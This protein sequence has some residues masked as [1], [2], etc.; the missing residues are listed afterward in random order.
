MGSR[1]AWMVSALNIC[2]K[3]R[4]C[5]PALSAISRRRSLFAACLV[6]LLLVSTWTALA[7]TYIYDPNGRLAVATNDAGES[8]RYR[9]DELGNLVAIERLAAD[10]LA[11]FG[12]SPG[13]GASGVAVRISGQGFSSTSGQNSVR[14]NGAVASVSI[15]SSIDL[16]A[17]VPAGATTGPITVTVGS[18]TASSTTDFIVDENARPPVIT[19]VSPQIASIGTA[20]TVDG[21]TL[22][23]VV[24]QTTLRLNQRPTLPTTLTN[25]QA[26]FPVP[27]GTSSGR[28]SVRTPYGNALS[29]QDVLVTPDSI[30]P[31]EIAQLKRLALDAAAQG[32]SVTTTGHYGAALFDGSSGDYLSAQFSS[33]S[34][35]NIN[36]ALYSISNTVLASGTVSSNSP[37]FHLP[38][39]PA[40]GTYLLLMKPMTGPVTWNLA[41]EKATSIDVNGDSSPVAT[42]AP[43]QSKRLLFTA[44]TGANL[45]L[46]ISDLVTPGSTSRVSINVDKPDGSSSTLEYCYASNNGCQLN[47]SNLAAGIYSVII[48]PPSNG[49]RTMSLQTMLSSNVIGPLARDMAQTLILARRG[50]NG[51]LTFAGTAGETMTLQL[52][53]QTTVP[54]NRT[55]YYTVYKPDGSLLTS[56][57]TTSAATLNLPNLPVTGNYTMFVDPR[58]GETLSVQMLLASGMTGE[59][60][61]DGESGSYTTT[62]LGQNVYLTFT[63]DAGQNLGL[64]ISNIV[65]PGSSSAIQVDVYGP[66]GGRLHELYCSEVYSRCDAN[67]PNLTAGIYSIVVEPPVD[68]NRTMSFQVTLSSD[69]TGELPRDTAAALNLARRGQNGRFTFTGTQGETVALQVVDQAT[70]PAEQNVYYM[71]YRPDGSY[72]TSMVTAAPETLNIS[73]LPVTG[74][75][76]V[77]V[78]PGFGAALVAETLLASGAR[79]LIELN[80]ASETVAT[81]IPG[82]HAYLAFTAAAGADLGLGISDLVTSWPYSSVFVDVRKPDGTNLTSRNCDAQYF[83]GCGLDLSDLEA[84][85]YTVVVVPPHDGQR[86][87]SFKAT[88]SSDVVQTMQPDVVTNLSLARRGQNGQLAFAGVE[89]QTVALQVTGQATVPVNRWS[90]Y[91]VYAPDGSY[92]TGTMTDSATTLDLPNLP[93]TGNYTVFVDPEQGEALNV[94]LTLDTTP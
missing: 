14:F 56:M 15:A 21:Q 4:A 80:G 26:V 20:I 65:T 61:I 30:L 59:I 38:R 94:Q 83:H 49:G 76:T 16:T 13:R 68:G 84:G 51:M 12:F 42:V 22:A 75:Y 19:N 10:D 2:A 55:T 27:S 78:D 6:T 66:D 54:A 36:Y 7:T 89:G 69:V 90:Y 87:M 39:L 73:N 72:L 48:Q 41:I 24:N 53:G 85:T 60:E 77:F 71:V 91:S 11:V 74:T 81:T 5:V 70:E 86:T 92:L 46:G 33:I 35:T 82:Q 64:G 9:Y 67:L 40:T 32:F 88:L 45:G 31:G 47:L 50:Q 43:A 1:T 93:A 62:M 37:T 57:G 28:V 29:E 8:A 34:A 44:S 63:A 25:S 3:K 79:D 17:I 52:T 58:Y 18:E 23:P